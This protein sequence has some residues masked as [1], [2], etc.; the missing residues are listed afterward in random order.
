MAAS[1]YSYC[2]QIHA[3]EEFS[4]LSLVQFIW[5]KVCGLFSRNFKERHLPSDILANVLSRVPAGCLHRC[6]YS[7]KAL[8]AVTINPFFLELHLSHASPVIAI[9]HRRTSGTSEVLHINF[10]DETAKQV[11][12]KSVSTKGGFNYMPSL[13]GSHN[14]FLI[15]R[16][17]SCRIDIWNPVTNQKLD[18]R[19]NPGF[20][21]FFGFYFHPVAMDYR[22]IFGFCCVTH[23][24]YN[25][26]RFSSTSRKNGIFDHP[27]NAQ[28]APIILNRALHW[29][30]CDE[31]YLTVIGVPS[32]CL[33][34][35]IILDMKSEMFC[36]IS[37]PGKQCGPRREHHKMKL[38]E[39]EG[40]LCLCNATSNQNLTIWMLEDYQNKVWGK[41]YVIATDPLIRFCSIEHGSLRNFQVFNKELLL[42]VSGTNILLYHLDLGIIRRVGK[43]LNKNK[44][45]DWHVIPV[46]HTNTLLSAH[47]SH[48]VRPRMVKVTYD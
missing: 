9:Y 31:S 38:M 15:F 16:R 34:S 29:M 37:H 22:A 11:T 28:S 7:C 27:P 43:P 5:D 39:M 30:V 8:G 36:S 24:R 48:S 32:D 3:G 6:E 46:V 19:I 35:I 17:A 26:Y 13:F 41:R 21:F 1:S 12:R 47:V 18:L 40:H 14:G 4:C 10:T 44:E 45:K 25:I 42:T 2:L 33:N 20:E 23:F